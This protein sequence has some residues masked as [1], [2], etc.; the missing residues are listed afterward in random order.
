ML[1]RIADFNFEI[2]NKYFILPIHCKDYIIDDNNDIDYTID[3]SDEQIE[4]EVDVEGEH[5][6]AYL[7]SIAAYRQIG[8]WLPLKNAFVLHAVTVDVGGVG[9]A[10]AA[11][12]GTGKS[13]HMMLWQKHLGDKML[14]VNGDKPIVRFFDENK[15]YAYGNPWNGKEHLGCNMRTELKHICFI[16]RAEKNETEPLSKGE[17][18][19]LILNQVYMPNNQAAAFN[20]FLLIDKLLS[21]CTLWRIKCNMDISA[22]ETAYAAILG[23]E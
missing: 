23:K 5:T 18:L 15:I 9:V 4:S 2:N 11:R 22:A 3:L 19:D 6:V 1:C 16:E 8:E 13:T 7:E 10:F 14:V 20:T 12:S 17:A 21:Y